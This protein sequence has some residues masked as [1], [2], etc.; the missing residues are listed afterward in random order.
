MS[1][2]DDLAKSF[3]LDG[4]PP[5]ASPAPAIAAP[6]RE[7]LENYLHFL[8]LVLAA[9]T[10]LYGTALLI[11]LVAPRPLEGGVAR[12][13]ARPLGSFAFGLA[14]L[15]VALGL[16]GVFRHHGALP[17]R[18][19]LGIASFAALAAGYAVCARALGA[20]AL[21]ERS[22]LAQTCVGLV[23]LVLPLAWPLGLPVAVIAGPLGL[24]AW[25][26]GMRRDGPR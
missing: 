20:R 23:A 4:E 2:A 11:A 21:P 6:L 10:A 18:R 26:L 1:D 9:M 25:L 16:F 8:P 17:G 24:G 3:G 13:R 5:V 14:L 12:L 22:A 19:L 15:A 7:F